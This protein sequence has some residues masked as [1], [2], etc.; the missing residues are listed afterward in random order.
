MKTYIC[1]LFITLTASLSRV[2]CSNDRGW[3]WSCD[4]L[5]NIHTEVQDNYGLLKLFSFLTPY[6]NKNSAFTNY[7]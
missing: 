4:D 3:A 5:Q 6:L 7:K 2:K 1:L